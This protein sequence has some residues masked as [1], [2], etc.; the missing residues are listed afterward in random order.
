[1]SFVCVIL[2]YNYKVFAEGFDRLRVVVYTATCFSFT[3]KAPLVQ[4]N[5]KR[6][7]P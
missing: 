5:I 2:G 3:R 1:M 4:I 6:P 7:E